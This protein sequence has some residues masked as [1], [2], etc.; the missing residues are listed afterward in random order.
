MKEKFTEWTVVK[1]NQINMAVVRA[2][3]VFYLSAWH[4]TVTNGSRIQ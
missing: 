4:N 2:S 1:A 3:A